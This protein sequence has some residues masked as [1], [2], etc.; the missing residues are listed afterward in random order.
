MPSVDDLEAV[1][2]ELYAHYDLEV[3]AAELGAVGSEAVYTPEA[4]TA[5]DARANAFADEAA[6]LKREEAPRLVRKTKKRQVDRA[7]VA[8]RFLM[9]LRGWVEGD[10]GVTPGSMG[11]AE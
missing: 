9:Q 8:K 5:L 1:I 6:E 2:D 11:T 10:V 7:L 3:V 4:V